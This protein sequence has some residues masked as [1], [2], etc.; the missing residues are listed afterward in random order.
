VRRKFLIDTDT[1]SDDAVALV[2]AL[3]S[4]AIDVKCITVVAGNCNLEQ[5]VQ[6][7]LYT[8]ELCGS[9][10][11]V[12]AGKAGPLSREPFDA[13]H[14]HGKDGMGDIGLPLYGRLPAGDDA[15]TR[16]IDT[17]HEHAGDIEVVTLGPLTN[18]A[19]A[20]QRDPGIAAKI[21][22]CTVMGG[23]PDG[24]GNVWPGS[25][26]NIY[27]DP[28]AARVVYHAGL[29]LRMVGW[30]I[31]RKYAVVTKDEQ[32]QLHAIG[33]ELAKFSHDIQR[34]VSNW[35]DNTTNLAGYDLPDPIAMAIAIDPGI[36]TKTARYYIDIE[37]VSEL[38][39]GQTVVDY[40]GTLGKVPNVELVI[41]ASHEQFMGLLFDS[42]R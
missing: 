17:V 10:A 12:Y 20:L 29:T 15:I 6:N 30:D 42:V 18:L 41:E 31:S 14:V 28:E 37:T 11:P 35:T 3:R 16:I 1:A 34:C 22:Q 26:F 39:R 27:A 8:V 33:T 40:N 21:K 32:Q 4:S 9:K 24:R 19:T 7:A 23:A 5:A 38:T 2:I 25:C 13:V 36:A